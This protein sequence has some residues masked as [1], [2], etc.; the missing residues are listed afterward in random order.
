[1]QGDQTD[2]T[3]AAPLSEVEAENARLKAEN[4]QLNGERKTF[5]RPDDL[6][7]A[8]LASFPTSRLLMKLVSSA[9]GLAAVRVA[10]D[11]VV[12][13]HGAVIK[14]LLE[15]IGRRYEFTT[16]P[17][18]QLAAQGQPMVFHGGALK[19]G[20]RKIGIIQLGLVPNGDFVIAHR[21][22]GAVLLLRDKLDIREQSLLVFLI[23]LA[24]YRDR[25]HVATSRKLTIGDRRPGPCDHPR[26]CK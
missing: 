11:A 7:G 19:T 21:R 9:F 22:S 23:L 6:F 25:D 2:I 20:E 16:K 15:S 26:P 5:V 24:G 3:S 14:D 10:G 4:A 8:E 18:I 12:P 1:V 13:L 17:P